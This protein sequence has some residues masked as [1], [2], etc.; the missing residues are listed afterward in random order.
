MGETL[1]G[2]KVSSSSKPMRSIVGSAVSN[3]L[4]MTEGE[5]WTQGC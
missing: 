2:V 3:P 1:G 5:L 4:V